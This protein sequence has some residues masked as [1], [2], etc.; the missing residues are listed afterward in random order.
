[1]ARRAGSQHANSAAIRR[2]ALSQHQPQHIA[3]PRAERHPDADLA[4]APADE[5]RDDPVDADRREQQRGHREEREQRHV[6]AP[7]A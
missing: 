4:A 7:R 3:T 2:H 5:E 1:M 6:E